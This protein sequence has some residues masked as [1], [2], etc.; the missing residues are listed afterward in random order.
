M[1][2]LRFGID[3]GGTFTDFALLD[4]G[5]LSVFKVPSTP[6][7]PQDA[8][9]TGLECLAG[10]RTDLSIIHGSTVATNAFLER[11]GARTVFL[12]TKGF[13]EI[14]YLARQSRPA[15]YDL[16]PVKP[17]AVLGPTDRMGVPERVG[18]DGAIRKRLTR[19]A[20]QKLASAVA[21]GG[22]E[23]AAVCLLFSYL[24][25]GH[26]QMLVEA[27]REKGVEAYGSAEVLA[28]AGEFERASATIL[29]AYLSPLVRT[30]LTDLVERLAPQS[31]AFMKSS[32]G[33]LSAAAAGRMGLHTLLSGPAGGL[34]GALQAAG[35]P[36]LIT[37]DMGGTSTDVALV[38]GKPQLDR[39]YT[40]DGWPVGVPMLD[41]RT[42]GAGGGSI[43]RVDRAGSLR[44]GPASAGADP[45]PA[46][47]GRGE[48][49]TV[50]DAHVVLGHIAPE[51]FLSG[52]M[53][54]DPDRSM[55]AA[56]KLGSRLGLS[57]QDVA[58]GVLTVVRSNMERAIRSV[59]IARGH[60]PT[61][62]ALV[63]FGGAGGLHAFSLAKSL[64][65]PR[66]IVPRYPGALSA[67][68]MLGADRIADAELGLTRMLLSVSLKAPEPTLA[69]PLASG[70]KGLTSAEAEGIFKTLEKKNLA[71][72]GLGGPSVRLHGQEPA[73]QPAAVHERFLSLTSLNRSGEIA[74]HWGRPEEM[75]A[76][77]HAAHKKQHGVEYLNDPVEVLS[78]KVKTI[79]AGEP[80]EYP[81]LAT[82]GNA[83]EAIVGRIRATFETE[84]LSVP[85]YDRKGMLAGMVIPGP[86]VVMDETATTLVPQDVVVEV[87]RVGNLI[88]RVR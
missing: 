22:Y 70:S 52:R 69:V 61:Q 49:F 63:P 9:F 50:T 11:R 39:D 51:R 24:A 55:R 18:P 64:K 14:P 7:R 87:D 43:A 8:V 85:L 10:R 5:K 36:S 21:A 48:E 60:D 58:S 12:G 6:R 20:A 62:F 33:C 41:I 65:V 45:G 68:G 16:K 46:C 71:E 29:N 73:T 44:V 35:E 19:T 3:I 40:I 56:E 25:S 4:S 76:A 86:A 80:V 88:G 32:G 78:L 15:L 82:G 79:L 81:T 59:S 34:T 42:I 54:L 17:P 38:E 83:S 74:V 37:F 57:I 47:Y 27:L 30:Y 53:G 2:E 13:E 84:L 77:F 75:L 26:E 31:F 1:G 72:L 67:L 28:R 23:S 66:V